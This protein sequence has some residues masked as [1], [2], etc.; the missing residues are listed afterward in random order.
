MKTKSKAPAGCLKL[1]THHKAIGGETRSI[2]VYVHKTTG[3]FTAVCGELHTKGSSP[4]A[5][6]DN[7]VKAIVASS[8]WDYERH[9]VVAVTH[10]PRD[11]LVGMETT[12]VDIVNDNS[13][14]RFVAAD[15]VPLGYRSGELVPKN[16]VGSLHAVAIVMLPHTRENVRALNDMKQLL[17]RFAH[18]LGDVVRQKNVAKALTAFSRKMLLGVV[19]K[20]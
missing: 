1:K 10:D 5:A 3:E 17:K 20:T 16:V 11:S 19:D 9:I 12:V 14:W 15:G 13:G 8:T 4:D 6:Y 18:D 7:M 2:D